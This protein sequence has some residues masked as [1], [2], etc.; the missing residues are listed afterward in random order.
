M[1]DCGAFSYINEDSPPQPFF[2][3][4]NVVNGGMKVYKC[5]GIELYTSIHNSIEIYP[6]IQ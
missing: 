4:E 1:G 5:G 6:G 2:S 3:V